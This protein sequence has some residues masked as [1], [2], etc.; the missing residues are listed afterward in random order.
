MKINTVLE[1]VGNLLVQE[2]STF[3]KFG[4]NIRF[5]R[6]GEH[7]LNQELC[8]TLP[9]LADNPTLSSIV[10]NVRIFVRY[11]EAYEEAYEG[12][13]RVSFY[14]KKNNLTVSYLIDA[15]LEDYALFTHTKELVPHLINLIFKINEQKVHYA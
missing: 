1:N 11:E 6:L 2:L 4:L 8:F 7:G 9:N 12:L 13:F 5:T 10:S 15:Q 14:N 3:Y